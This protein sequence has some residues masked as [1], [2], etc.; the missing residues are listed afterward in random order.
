MLFVARILTRIIIRMIVRMI[1]G[2]RLTSILLLV[3]T[4]L[5]LVIPSLIPLPH[6]N[7]ARELGMFY[8][9]VMACSLN[10]TPYLPLK[11]SE[12]WAPEFYGVDVVYIRDPHLRAHIKGPHAGFLGVF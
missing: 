12:A 5:T 8:I 6:L 10:M 1:L 7:R 11:G 4:I 9:G 3:V 2:T